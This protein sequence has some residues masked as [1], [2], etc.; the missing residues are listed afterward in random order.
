MILMIYIILEMQ[1][2]FF[3]SWQVG[4]A[5]AH[6]GP[7]LEMPLIPNKFQRD[8]SL[9][10]KKTL[11]PISDSSI[12]CDVLTRV[13]CSFIMLSFQV[14]NVLNSLSHTCISTPKI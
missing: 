2:N 3:H 8:S 5:Q 10:L 4:R 13:P 14:I 11:I 1:I 12:V 6:P 7:P 9:K